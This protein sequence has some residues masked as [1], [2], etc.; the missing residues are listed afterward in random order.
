M[1]EPDV[2]DDVLSIAAPDCG[3]HSSTEDDASKGTNK[4]EMETVLVLDEA[5]CTDDSGASDVSWNEDLVTSAA[6]NVA[7]GSA[8]V[9]DTPSSS[10]G[11]TRTFKGKL[12]TCYVCG[13]SAHEKM[14]RHVM[15][16]HLPWY[17]YPH[18]ACWECLEQET[19]SSSLAVRHSLEH[20]VGYTFDD[21]HL[22]LWCMLVNGAL[23]FLAKC[24]KC[25][26]LNGLLEYVLTRQLY[27]RLKSGFS[28]QEYRFLNFYVEHHGPETD[29]RQLCFQPPNHIICLVN[30]ELTACL[31]R[32]ISPEM[33]TEFRQLASFLTYEGEDVQKPDRDHLKVCKEPFWFIDAHF[34]LD[35]TLRR[36][37]F[38]NFLHMHGALASSNGPGFY[39][40]I[41]NFVFSKHWEHWRTYIGN[42]NSIF[43]TFGIHPHEASHGISSDQRR[44][45]EKL[46]DDE[47]CVAVGEVGIDYTTRCDHHPC[48]NPF[49]CIRRM[50][51]NQESA[52]I[53]QLL[54]ARDRG[55]P[56]VL[57]CRDPGDG[58]ALQ[59]TMDI[60]VRFRCCHMQVHLHCFVGTIGDLN[61]WLLIIPRLVVGVTWK[62]IQESPDV[63]ARIPSHQLV[64][65]SDAPYLHPRST[66]PTN[67]PWN[68]VHVAERVSRIRNIP[69]SVLNREVNENTIRFYGIDRRLNVASRPHQGILS[70][71]R[72]GFD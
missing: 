5:E 71:T 1:A 63:I 4:D 64:L 61:R 11:P 33:Q 72:F 58:S 31:L 25:D 23:H 67:H 45:L 66:S 20:N 49:A 50:R 39:Y 32:R 12:R 27:T 30:W 43:P 52:F 42:N 16:V 7:G 22:H 2:D 41:A 51:E 14:R 55:L 46:V 6:R 54:M 36:L 24:L 8:L 10:S 19:Q 28:E 65:E 48:R 57:H 29:I 56:I 38:R 70:S 44:H 34:H 60:L 13:H 40:G 21:N 3:W 26:G 53:E 69:M 18:T 9:P 47:L 35:L 37:R 59:R 62:T 68:I 15:K 17:W